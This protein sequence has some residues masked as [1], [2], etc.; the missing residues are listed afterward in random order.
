M[1]FKFGDV[2]I[3]PGDQF[4]V[5]LPGD[6]LVIHI[7]PGQLL[8]QNFKEHCI[9]VVHNGLVDAAVGKGTAGDILALPL[10]HQGV[11]TL[12]A[13]EG[14]ELTLHMVVVFKAVVAAGGVQNPIADIDQVQQAP[15][16]LLCQ[17]D[18]HGRGLLSPS[19]LA[20]ASHRHLIIYPT[21]P[22]FYC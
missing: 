19:V 1:G 6:G 2:V 22:F 4:V 7:P 5:I 20:G 14:E 12:A 21:P 10:L 15:E 18:L 13:A 9:L 3:H 11:H 16:F 17:I 8:G